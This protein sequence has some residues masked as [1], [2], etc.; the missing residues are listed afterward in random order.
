MTK[1]IIIEAVALA[2]GAGLQADDPIEEAEMIIR[3]LRTAGYRIVPTEP[4]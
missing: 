2:V 1:D 4:T 3:A